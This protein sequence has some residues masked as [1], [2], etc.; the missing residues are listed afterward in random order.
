MSVAVGV[1]PRSA[2]HVPGQPAVAGGTLPK[3]GASSVARDAC[4]ATP[5]REILST[6]VSPS[7]IANNASRTF[8]RDGIAVAMA[9]ANLAVSLLPAGVGS[10]W[11]ES[12]LAVFEMSPGS[13][14]RTLMRIVALEPFVSVPIAQVTVVVPPQLP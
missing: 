2:T 1:S 7:R 13:S 6:A 5:H 10:D 14:M 3:A 4:Y 12:T 9:A 11:T 8:D